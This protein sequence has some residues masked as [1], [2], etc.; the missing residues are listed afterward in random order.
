MLAKRWIALGALALVSL[1]LGTVFLGSH[2]PGSRSLSEEELAYAFRIY[3]EETDLS[4]VRVAYD[5]PYT[6]VSSMTLGETIHVDP[7]VPEDA[8]GDL[9]TTARGRYLLIHEL[10]H[11]MDHREDGYSYLYLSFAAQTRA[12][13]FE[14]DRLAAYDWR[15]RL[16]EGTPYGSWNPEERAEAIAAFAF[17]IDPSREGERPEGTDRLACAIPLFRDRFCAR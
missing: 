12:L 2:Y 5:T 9:T 3:G 15:A 16:D 6:F 8:S 17:S 4:S 13:I 11:V 10:A 1:V 14:G 7:G